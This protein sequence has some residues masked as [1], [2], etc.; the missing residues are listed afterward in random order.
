MV[1]VCRLMRVLDGLLNF[2]LFKLTLKLMLTVIS[3]LVHKTRKEQNHT[4]PYLMESSGV[5]RSLNAYQSSLTIMDFQTSNFL[6]PR[7]SL[8]GKAFNL[9]QLLTPCEKLSW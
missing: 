5:V 4:F 1:L 2:Y 9:L 3:R 6:Y 7:A 8:S